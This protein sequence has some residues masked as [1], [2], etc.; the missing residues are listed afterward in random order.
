MDEVAP[1]PAAQSSGESGPSPMPGNVDGA[2]E[3]KKLGGV[4]EQ[5][6]DAEEEPEDGEEE[7]DGGVEV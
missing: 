3:E 7:E 5:S 1:E 6:A 4:E 2:L